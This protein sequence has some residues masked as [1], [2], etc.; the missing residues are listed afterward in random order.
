MV[1]KVLIAAGT[2][3]L[4][5]GWEFLFLLLEFPYVFHFTIHHQTKPCM[6]P[7]SHRSYLNLSLNF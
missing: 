2:P 4:T 1:F 7:R 5:P 6:P 3:V